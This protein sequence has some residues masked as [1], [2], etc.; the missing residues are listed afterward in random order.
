[1]NNIFVTYFFLLIASVV[2]SSGYFWYVSVKYKI[3]SLELGNTKSFDFHKRMKKYIEVLGPKS[4]KG[5]ALNTIIKWQRINLFLF[6][7]L[8]IVFFFSI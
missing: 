3:D 6:L 2:L 7:F 5:K 8:P 1:M 4:K